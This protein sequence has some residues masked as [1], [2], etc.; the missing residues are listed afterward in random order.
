[1]NILD[2]LDKPEMIQV[3]IIQQLL[4]N[5]GKMNLK[6]LEKQV[7][8]SSASLNKY[9]DLMNDLLKDFD[10]N[11]CLIIDKKKVTL[12]I[13]YHFNM[14]HILIHYL[15]QSINCSIIMYLSKHDGFSIS[16]LCQEL[17][18]SEATLFRRLKDINRLI[19]EF[20]IQIKNAKFTGDELQ[21]RYFLFEFY[22]HTLPIDVINYHPLDPSI[23]LLIEN[24]ADE[25][26]LP[27]EDKNLY[28]LYLWL[29]ISKRRELFGSTLEIDQQEVYRKLIEESF[30][31]AVKKTN[32]A[33]QGNFSAIQTETD[34]ICLYI[35]FIST[36]IYE[37]PLSEDQYMY[38]LKNEFSRDIIN[39]SENTLETIGNHFNLEYLSDELLWYIECALFQLHF[40]MI[41][42]N[43]YMS[44]FESSYLMSKR[45][46]DSI[47]TIV[48]DV[49]YEHL[50]LFSLNLSPAVYDHI[51]LNYRFILQIIESKCIKSISVGL[52]NQVNYLAQQDILK[53]LEMT[54]SKEFDI[55]FEIADREKCYD[56][57]VTDI[58]LTESPYKYQQIYVINEIIN[59]YDENMIRE[60]L[61]NSIEKD[62]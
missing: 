1:M 15:N 29:L 10:A 46:D 47:S 45:M 52:A 28:H 44:Y 38:F 43:S 57:L 60:I 59:G 34:L 11:I 24:L 54:F 55:S 35:F 62:S 40:R 42:F 18:I 5:G 58:F 4:D 7:K 25:L 61:I 53:R 48:N 21:I 23:V 50:S 17:M 49:I 31:T 30:M 2:L 32:Q 20:E 3:N 33:L 36:Y 39:L 22:N 51:F 14:Q 19:A 16:R 9:L 13:P 27:I 56:L 37:T 6:E 8:I 12:N 41:H 26:E